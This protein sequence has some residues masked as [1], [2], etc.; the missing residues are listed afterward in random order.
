MAEGDGKLVLVA[1]DESDIVELLTILLERAGYEVL[2]A[3]DGKT[4]LELA[5]ER[6]PRLC[7]LDGTMP[8]LAGFEVLRALREE[9][10]MSGV[11]VAILT[12]TVEE[13]REI[14]RHGVRPEAFLRKPFD[15]DRL[16]AEVSRL[17]TGH[18]A[19]GS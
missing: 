3:A 9:E 14:S 19:G 7:I 4:A 11:A 18:R 12:A 5:R 17:V 16:L 1:D 13:E 2:T 6:R 8:G 15:S 10:S